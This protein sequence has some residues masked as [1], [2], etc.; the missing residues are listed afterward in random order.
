M[1]NQQ[2]V[3]ILTSTSSGTHGVTKGALSSCLLSIC[4]EYLRLLF[5]PVIN[6]AFYDWQIRTFI[7]TAQTNND[8]TKM[9]GNL[10]IYVDVLSLKVRRSINRD[11]VCGETG[12][13][14]ILYF[15]RC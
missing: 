2:E 11:D 8:K 5:G 14:H 12:V 4:D 10:V 6:F 13:V 7:G 9:D 3:N 15:A 1:I